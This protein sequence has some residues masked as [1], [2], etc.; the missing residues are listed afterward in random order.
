[1][2]VLVGR[3]AMAVCADHRT[4][5]CGPERKRDDRAHCLWPV[6]GVTSYCRLA[7]WLFV[8]VLCLLDGA[9]AINVPLPAG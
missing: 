5:S 9:V 8:C 4:W 1:M 3:R 2:C 7:M 6:D